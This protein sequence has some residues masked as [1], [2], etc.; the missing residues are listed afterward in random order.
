MSEQVKLIITEEDLT[1]EDRIW[2][3]KEFKKIETLGDDDAGKRPIFDIVPKLITRRLSAMSIPG[4]RVTEVSVELGIS[5][6]LFGTGLEGKAIIKLT[7][8]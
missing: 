1:D 8:E 6:K 4:F 5:G 2:L 3:E 7:R